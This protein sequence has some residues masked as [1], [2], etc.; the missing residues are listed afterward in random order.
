MGLRISLATAPHKPIRTYYSTYLLA[1]QRRNAT[2]RP[3]GRLRPG[4]LTDLG[5]EFPSST[6]R[7]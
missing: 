7:R 5:L 6:E 3:K 1:R 2:R 4:P